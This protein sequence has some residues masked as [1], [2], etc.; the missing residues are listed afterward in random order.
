MN[1]WRPY[2]GAQRVQT[3]QRFCQGA[4]CFVAQERVAFHITI[5]AAMKIAAA[6]Q[7]FVLIPAFLGYAFGADVLREDL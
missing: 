3:G 4:R 6:Q 1:E 5:F 7:S 2:G